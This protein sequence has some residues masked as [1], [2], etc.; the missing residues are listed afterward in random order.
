MADFKWIFDG[1]GT[2]LNDFLR[3]K[4]PTEIPGKEISNSKI[5]RLIVAGS[6][7]VDGRQCR[8]PS[9]VL[10]KGST[11]NARVQEDK[12]FFEK[13]P[14]DI[15]YTLD[16]GDVLFEDDSIIVVDK[17]AFIPTEGTIVKDRFSMHQA[18][19]DYL[20]KKNPGL[21]NP[22]YVGIMHRLDR[23]TSGVL[24]FTKTRSV[25]PKVHEMF[26]N[27]LAVKT[28]RAVCCGTSKNDFFVV[29]NFIG[30]ISPKSSQCKMGVLPESRG[31]QWSKT[32]FTIKKTMEGLSYVDCRLYTGRTHQIR[33]HLSLSGM[34]ILGDSLYGGKK[35]IP[36][37]NNRIMLHA[38]S[39]EF[40]HPVSGETMKIESPLPKFFD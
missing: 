35:G 2:S 19:V 38:F 20:W 22:P 39:L 9:F 26:E 21:R 40:P 37:L 10:K 5:R 6:V 25:N 13:K 30:R 1:K 14:D 34:A 8:I 27:H 32:E 18:V 12:L 16:N 33:L 29:E 17:P 24:L 4:L 31:G 23:E 7:S 15:E 11:I 3:I 28:Y 36:Q